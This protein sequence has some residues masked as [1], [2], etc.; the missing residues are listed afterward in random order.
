VA[1]HPYPSKE[2]APDVHLKWQDNFDDIQMV[3]DYLTE[4]GHPAAIWV[5]EWGWSSATLGTERQA[6]YT[7]TSLRMIREQFPYVEIATMFVD[8]DRPTYAQGLFDSTGNPKPAATAF[9]R[10]AR[11][12]DPVVPAVQSASAQPQ[13]K[14]LKITAQATGCFP[15]RGWVDLRGQGRK[16]RVTLR[17]T[18]ARGTQKIR[19]PRGRWRWRI[20]LQDGATGRSVRSRWRATRVR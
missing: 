7:A 9:A 3:R 10:A 5:T 1:L 17:L 14:A 12:A 13:R 8:Y 15:C 4:S 18:D 2:H 19:L 16:R 11:N 6:E 20:T